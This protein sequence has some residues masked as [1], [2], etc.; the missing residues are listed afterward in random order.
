MEGRD[1]VGQR[2]GT[3]LALV[4]ANT[5]AFADWR[6]AHTRGKVLSRETG[7]GRDYGANPYQSYD[8]PDLR[9]FLFNGRASA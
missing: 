5:I 3:R 2:A 9:P 1:I 6:V 7:H 4:P 8:Q